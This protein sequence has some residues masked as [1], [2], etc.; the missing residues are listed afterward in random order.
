ME[1]IGLKEAL[2][3]KESFNDM[4]KKADGNLNVLTKSLILTLLNS[5]N[6]EDRKKGEI[7]KKDYME[8]VII[9]TYKNHL[10]QF[11]KEAIKRNLQL[12]E[13][14]LEELYLKEVIEEKERFLT[15]KWI[16]E[17]G[18][19]D[20]IERRLNMLELEKKIVERKLKVLKEFMN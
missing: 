3:G 4:L 11:G 9:K 8:N 10:K 2:K 20:L 19:Q 18:I 17:H 6:E 15:K 5:P 1:I 7:L 12:E 13:L 16:K 14:E